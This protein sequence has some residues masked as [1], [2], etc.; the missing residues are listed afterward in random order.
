MKQYLSFLVF[1]IA[2]LL[3]SS[4]ADTFNWNK[5]RGYEPFRNAG[6]DG[7]NIPNRTDSIETDIFRFPTPT[8]RLFL[9]FKARNKNGNPGKTYTYLTRDGKTCKTSNPFWGLILFSENDTIAFSVTNFE[10]ADGIESKPACILKLSRNNLSTEQE[11][12]LSSGIN[13]FNGF[14]IW[15]LKYEDGVFS[16]SAGDHGV[17]EVLSLPLPFSDINAVGFFSG[18][19]ADLEVRDIRLDIYPENDY[20][21]RKVDIEGLNKYLEES[22]DPMEGYWTLFDRELEETLLKLGGDYNLA[23]VMEVEDYLLIYLDGARV[24]REAWRPGDVK[25]FLRKSPFPGIFNVEWL[26][27]QK[28]P[29]SNEIKAQKGEGNT[30]SIQFPYQSSRIRLR[31]ILPESLP[32][33]GGTTTSGSASSEASTETTATTSTGS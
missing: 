7:I 2:G 24:N 18:W 32:T 25:A 20:T 26:D 6:P 8:D 16:I 17:K 15:H 21:L 11:V 10:I 14:N 13:P 30:L 29:M 23:C 9:S 5:R 33:S 27:S 3:T 4:A 12:T 28:D 19:G 1:I 31:K 22:E